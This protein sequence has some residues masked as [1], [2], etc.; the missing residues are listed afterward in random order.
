MKQKTTEAPVPMGMAIWAV[1]RG[2]WRTEIIRDPV[3]SI[4]RSEYQ[5]MTTLRIAR[6]TRPRISMTFL[7]FGANRSVNHEMAM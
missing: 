2:T 6:R 7:S 5:K 1:H 4:Q 3:M